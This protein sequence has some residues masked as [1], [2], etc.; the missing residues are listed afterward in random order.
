MS[1]TL[2]EF[3][4]DLLS[5]PQVRGHYRRLAPF[6]ALVRFRLAIRARIAAMNGRITP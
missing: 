4:A 5:D 2:R 6:Y 1:K 3:H